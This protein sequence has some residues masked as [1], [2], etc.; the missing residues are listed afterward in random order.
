M[1]RPELFLV[2]FRLDPQTG[3]LRETKEFSHS[4]LEALERVPQT[5]KGRERP[6]VQLPAPPT[7]HKAR[8]AVLQTHPD[9]TS[10]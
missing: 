4:L 1:R 6:S 5:H 3:K 2:R 9:K 8:S 7:L 10:P